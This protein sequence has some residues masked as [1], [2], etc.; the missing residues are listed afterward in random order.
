MI[1]TSIKEYDKKRSQ[2]YIDGEKA[3]LLYKGE[4][5]KYKLEQDKEIDQI[6]YDVIV[7]EVLGKRAIL[8]AMNLLQKRDY[9]E[10]KLREKLGDGGYPDSCIE[11]AIDYV[12]S[13]KYLDDRRYASDY[14]RYYKESR[15][16]KR[17][18]Q[19]LVQKGINKD[20]ITEVMEEEYDSEDEDIE[21]DQ[22]RHLLIKKHYSLSMD[23][24]DKQKIMAF[25][26]R[27]GY[28]TELIYKAMDMD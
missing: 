4:I 18:E 8:R 21:L 17:I 25:L 2:I 11:D 7:R 27:K 9:T 10:Y 20:L 28:S 1:I 26:Y 14:A 22:I 24:K 12:K 6:T 19:D 23:Y 15:S 13:Y 5:R 3:F 16:R